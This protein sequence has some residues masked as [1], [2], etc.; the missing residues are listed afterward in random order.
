MEMSDI[1][2][3]WAVDNQNALMNLMILSSMK[4]QHDLK[5]AQREF[6]E[7]QAMFDR[8]RKQVAERTKSE[9]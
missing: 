1:K 9:G 4:S 2:K 7:V 3:Y 8:Y 6:N 5:R